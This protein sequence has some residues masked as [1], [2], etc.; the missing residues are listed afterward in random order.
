MRKFIIKVNGNPYEVEVEEIGRSD[1]IVKT[2]KEV[3]KPALPMEP[4]KTAA[5]TKQEVKV[6]DVKGGV[7]V[8]APLPGTIIKVNVKAGDIV[9]KDQVLMVLE[10]MKMENELVSPGDGKV[11]SINTEKGKAVNAGEV[12]IS[13]E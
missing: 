3:K 12:L 8:K 7:L 10:A 6:A 4:Q 11:V 2:V 9:K 1:S 13:I 5:P